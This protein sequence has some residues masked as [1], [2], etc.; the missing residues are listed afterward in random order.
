MGMNVDQPKKFLNNKRKDKKMLWNDIMET[1]S[2]LKTAI[3]FPSQH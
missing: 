3:K 2:K 1:L